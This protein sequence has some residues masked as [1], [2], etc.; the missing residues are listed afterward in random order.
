MLT[1][2]SATVSVY[3]YNL[4]SFIREEKKTGTILAGQEREK[5]QSSLGKYCLGGLGLK[6]V[7]SI[8]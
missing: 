1:N 4:C 3:V 7:Y 5:D 8:S 6:Q 2:F